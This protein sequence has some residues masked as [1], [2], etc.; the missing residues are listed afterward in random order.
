MRPELDK[1]TV[2]EIKAYA[3]DIHVSP[4]KARLV[5]KMLKSLSVAEALT[6]LDFIQK[7]A[8]WPIKKLVNSAVANAAHNFQ[9]EADRLF[10]KNL[11]A[12]GG[13]VMMRFA[14]RAQGRAS[15]V[16][17]RTSHLSLILGVSD[18]KSKIKYQISKI[19]PKEVEEVPR[20][21]PEFPKMVEPKKSR[22]AF[23]RK[24][25]PQDTS[26]L[27]PKEDVKGKKYTSFDR[28]GNM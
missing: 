9:I 15:P 12:D 23:W 2:T 27:A 24:K 16:R 11:T 20:H 22:F 25:K 10:I 3:R 28:R 5:V 7:K 6:Q 14:P 8:A 17:K 21:E 26:Q 4:R 1:K 18:G 13:R 19:R